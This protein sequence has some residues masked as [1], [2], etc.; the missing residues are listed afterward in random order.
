MTT[1]VKKKDNK[2]DLTAYLFILPYAVIFMVFIV[3][4]LVISL[5]LSFTY[6]DST[7]TN[8]TGCKVDI[9]SGKSS[10]VGGDFNVG[11]EDEKAPLA[12][13]LSTT[14]LVLNEK[15]LPREVLFSCPYTE[16]PA[17][18]KCGR[19]CIK[20][21]GGHRPPAILFSTITQ[22]RALQFTRL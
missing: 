16:T 22:S 4:L 20:H 11:G 8:Q 21:K 1:S 10:F 18:I 9:L 3:L 13:T 15:G 12:V 14:E 6:Y 5:L 19:F 17:H 2:S 7:V